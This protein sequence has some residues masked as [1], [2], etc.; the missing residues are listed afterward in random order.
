MESKSLST[1]RFRATPARL[2]L[3]AAV[4]HVIVALTVFT[5]GRLRIMPTQFDAN[6]I[7]AFASDGYVYQIEVGNLA[8]ALRTGGFRAW[9]NTPALL[10][11]LRPYSLV[12]APLQRWARVSVATLEPLNLIY[13][14]LLLILVF[15]L[16]QEVFDRR[17]GLLAATIVGLW[18]SLLLHTTQ[19][20]KDPLLILAVLTVVLIVVQWLTRVYSPRRVIAASVAAAFAALT[21]SIVRL[22]MWDMI[23]ALAAVGLILL[24]VRQVRERRLLK[25][26]CA[27]AVLLILVIL[28]IPYFRTSFQSELEQEN[29]SIAERV[30]DLPL[31]ERI[32]K[33]RHGFGLPQDASAGSNIDMGVRFESKAELSRYIPRAVAIGLFAPFPKLWFAQGTQTGRG[34]RWL[35]G[36]ETLLTYLIEAL[37]AIGLWQNRRQLTVWLLLATAVLGTTALGLIVLNIG[38]LYRLRYPFW[39]LLVVLGAGG[40][41]K[42]A[43]AWK[44]HSTG[45]NRVQQLAEAEEH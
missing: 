8:E 39:I 7:G 34:G 35:S 3:L 32:T 21:I 29:L 19:I 45:E 36:A 22:A 44:Q 1:A 15:K 27:S 23:R 38:S 2:L 24:V 17:A 43:G 31:W 6:G 4:L 16:G 13:Y 41:S 42:L 20:V 30:A 9:F 26:N 37:A 14:L 18:P 33:R 5:I 12:G 25:A 28:V 40:A 11:H 10:L